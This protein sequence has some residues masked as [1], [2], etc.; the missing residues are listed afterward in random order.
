MIF[1]MVLWKVCAVK[2]QNDLEQTTVEENTSI[3]FF[4]NAEGKKITIV[5]TSSFLTAL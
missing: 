4:N 1:Y 2:M 3:L 5:Y